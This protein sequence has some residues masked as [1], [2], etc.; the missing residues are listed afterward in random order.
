MASF[1]SDQLDVAAAGTAEALVSTATYVK[2]VTIRA[3]AGNTNNVYIG[4]SAVTSANGLI[5]AAND[6][7]TIEREDEF[8]LATIYADVDTDGEGVSFAWVSDHD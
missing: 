8:N 7:V 2:S 6:V 3:K 1:G 4:A 5:L